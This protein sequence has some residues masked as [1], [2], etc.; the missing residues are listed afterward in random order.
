MK[1]THHLSLLTYCFFILLTSADGSP[2]EETFFDRSCSN[3][4]FE[5]H[6]GRI[7][8][9]DPEIEWGTY[10]GGSG[11]EGLNAVATD[12]LGNVYACGTTYGSD[13]LASGGFQNFNPALNGGIA[14]AY[15][16]K[17]NSEGDR[18]WAT[19][20]GGGGFASFTGAISVAVDSEQNVY[21]AG[22]TQDSG[23][24]FNGF[25]NTY[26]G[27][28]DAFL[29]KFNAA[30]ERLWATYLGGS[31]G[32]VARTIAIDNQDNVYITGRTFSSDFPVLN[33]YQETPDDEIGLSGDAFLAKF[34]PSGDLLWST[35]YGGA[36]QE[37]AFYVSCDNL[38]NVFITGRTAS[39]DDIFL[40]GHQ[41][42]F[43][44]GQTDAFLAK[45]NAAGV[46]Q[47]SSYYGGSG[48]DI[49]YGC[50]S[51]NLGN[52][53]IS[54]ETGS[55]NNMASNGFQ[56]TFAEAFLAKF[57]T[58]GERLWGTYYGVGGG[59]PGS[60][61]NIGYACATDMENN[62]YMAGITKST[63]GIASNGFQS[64]Y[65][66]G[67]S[68]AYIVSFTAGGDRLWG[69]Y[70]GGSNVDLARS[71]YVDEASNVYLAGT[72][73]S[74][75]GIFSNGFQST[76]EN[77]TGFVTK[78]ITCPDPQLI[79]LP[80]EV[81]SGASLSLNL[82]PSGGTLEL[83]GDGEINQTTFIAPEVM[84]TTIVTLQYTTSENGLC[85][86]AVADFELV[87]LPNIPAAVNLLTDAEEICQ[88][89]NISILANA[90]NVGNAPNTEWFLNGQLA[91]EGG[92]TFTSSTLANNDVVQIEIESS[93][94]CSTPNPVLSNA[95]T[96]TVN[97]IPSLSLV[98]SNIQG[99]TL[100]TDFGFANYQ[101]FLDGVIIPGATSST[102]I[103][104]VNGMYTVTA[105]NEFGCE[106]SESISLFT[107][108]LAE[109]IQKKVLIYPNPT[110]GS[111][112]INFGTQVPE[113]YTIFN[114]IGEVVY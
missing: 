54:G 107:V 20:Y 13:S 97:P 72:T 22:F 88:N 38:D 77:E 94:L 91:Q 78:I 14:A 29:V 76:Q 103:P 114:A 39:T 17:F 86:S 96:F 28:T 89:D 48:E 45:Y 10:Y 95:I 43:G 19:Y 101:W 71:L 51:D 37:F 73:N 6:D 80:E 68:D 24:S 67:S 82:F 49:A 3:H 59:G 52:I 85:S 66:G 105:T 26:N 104:S 98:F 12:A 55:S 11:T 30:G 106:S 60:G 79:G 36:E 92:L 46:L 111:L 63:S 100:V 50:V 64:S 15:L 21:I 44:G 34:D 53:Y 93:N 75:E 7:A 102:L 56:N 58:N 35:Y 87:I 108:S 41:S 4:A 32:E 16:V 90:E 31:D 23:L 33:G 2:L 1:T 109:Q 83:L 42:E 74:P 25:Q 61:A 69:S 62:V 18:I 81:C 40:D 70:Y 8:A 112:T 65:G 99:G 57:N 27:S 5:E 84:D 9:I 47:W 113:R 110:D